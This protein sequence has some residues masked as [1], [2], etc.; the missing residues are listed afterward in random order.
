MKSLNDTYILLALYYSINGTL[1]AF[2]QNVQDKKL[3]EKKNEIERRDVDGDEKYKEFYLKKKFATTKEAL[4]L[5]KD[6]PLLH[7]PG[8]CDGRV[9]HMSSTGAIFNCSSNVLML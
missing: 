2:L 4:E 8:N 6:D 1:Y 3:K 5:F 9:T 7:K